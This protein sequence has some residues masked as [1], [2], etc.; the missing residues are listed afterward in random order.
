MTD[1]DARAIYPPGNRAV[2]SHQTL[3]FVLGP[4]IGVMETLCLLEHV[5][6]KGALIEPGRCDR[7]GVM[8]TA[9]LNLFCS[10]DRVSGTVQIGGL[11]AF[12]ICTQVIDCGQLEEVIDFAL[13]RLCILLGNSQPR[14]GQVAGDCNDSLG[15]VGPTV[16]DQL[17]EFLLGSSAHQDVH[18]PL[19]FQQTVDQI[20]A[21]KT[22]SAGDKV[23]HEVASPR[24]RVVVIASKIP[25][26]LTPAKSD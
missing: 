20:A 24:C 11:I 13:Q 7:R 15:M 10:L 22:G 16:L 9:R 6:P 2:M 19:A 21:D 1:D 18:G 4:E 23:S 5:F 25:I 3:G 12:S 14:F 26:A 8:E 17:I